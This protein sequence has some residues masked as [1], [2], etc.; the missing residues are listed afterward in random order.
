MSSMGM[1]VENAWR[2]EV[3]SGVDLVISDVW[4]AREGLVSTLDMSELDDSSTS[5]MH[6][7]AVEACS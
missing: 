3:C 7:H 6:L 2:T 4:L 5:V 1:N